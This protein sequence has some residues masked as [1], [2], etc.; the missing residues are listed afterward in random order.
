MI[1]QFVTFAAIKI[2]L[3]K[4]FLDEKIFTSISSICFGS[5]C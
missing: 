2:N 4:L 5:K 3:T 1:L